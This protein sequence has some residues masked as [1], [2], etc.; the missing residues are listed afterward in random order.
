VALGRKIALFFAEFPYA[1]GP[2]FQRLLFL[3]IIL[4]KPWQQILVAK[5]RSCISSLI[6]MQWK[7]RVEGTLHPTL[8]IAAARVTEGIHN[9]FLLRWIH[10]HCQM[11]DKSRTMYLAGGAKGC[12]VLQQTLIHERKGGLA[13]L[14]DMQT[15]PALTSRHS[16][17]LRIPSLS[18]LL[19]SSISLLQIAL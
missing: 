13:A 8:G 3:I 14:G 15:T 7:V 19:Q 6:S 9:T 16:K 10:L 4:M 17:H 2:L 1:C 18:S 12:P 11:K 5:M